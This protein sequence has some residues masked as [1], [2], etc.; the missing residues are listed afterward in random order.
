MGLIKELYIRIFLLL[1]FDHKNSHLKNK[2]VG[3]ASVV[4]VNSYPL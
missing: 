4:Y 1:R 3:H 2:V